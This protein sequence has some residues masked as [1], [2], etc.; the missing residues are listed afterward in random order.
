M[1]CK[2]EGSRAPARQLDSSRPCAEGDVLSGKTAGLNKQLLA[3]DLLSISLMHQEDRFLQ[4]SIPGRVST[5][6]AGWLV[7]RLRVWWIGCYV[8]SLVGWFGLAWFGE[9]RFHPRN[10]ERLAFSFRKRVPLAEPRDLSSEQFVDT[11]DLSA[12]PFVKT[13][14]VSSGSL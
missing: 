9:P 11:R 8:L 10:T 1:P 4:V 14:D 13:R 7:D 12:R 3:H 6:L 5:W 2:D